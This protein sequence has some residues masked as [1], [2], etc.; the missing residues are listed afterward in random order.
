MREEREREKER[1]MSYGG[2]AREERGGGERKGSYVLI[3]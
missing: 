2:K 1:E 3:Y